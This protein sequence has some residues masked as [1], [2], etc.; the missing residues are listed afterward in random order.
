MRSL[1]HLN[2][3]AALVEEFENLL[4]LIFWVP[5]LEW[6]KLIFLMIEDLELGVFS[7]GFLS[8]KTGLLLSLKADL[9]IPYSWAACRFSYYE[10][11]AFD[12]R[13]DRVWSEFE[14]ISPI[15]L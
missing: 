3:R 14:S 15:S 5:P 10:A 12:V 7:K 11:E 1:T 4:E 9:Y 6:E 8:Y 13:C 2:E